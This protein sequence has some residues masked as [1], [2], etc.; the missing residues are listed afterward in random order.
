MRTKTI[1]LLLLALTTP[2]RGEDSQV[3]TAITKGQWRTVERLLANQNDTVS[4][5]RRGEARRILGYLDAAHAD[6]EIAFRQAETSEL[7]I[8]AGRTSAET[9]MAMNKYAE[10]KE[11]LQA[12]PNGCTAIECVKL[13]FLKGRL[14]AALNNPNSA[15]SAFQKAQNHAQSAGLTTLS[16]QA[17]LAAMDIK[18]ASE[19]ELAILI[20]QLDQVKPIY[21]Q[22]ALRL[23]LAERTHLA[24]QQTL[25]QTLLNQIAPYIAPGRQR[26][27]FFALQA[28]LLEDTKQ[29]PQALRT[30]GNGMQAAS[31]ISAGDLLMHGEWQR[32]RLYRALQDPQRALA[33]Y[34]RA[35]FYLQAIRCD[36]PIRYQSGKS[37]FRKTLGP[38]Y[39]QTVDLLLTQAETRSEVAA[40][41][42]LLEARNIIESLK[43]A[44]LQ[45]YLG[46]TCPLPTNFLTNLENISPRTGVLYPIILDDRLVLLLGIGNLQY[47]KVVAIDR[48]TFS[49]EVRNFAK[50]LRELYSAIPK[51]LANKMFNWLITPIKPRLDAAGIDTLVI[52]PDGPLRLFSLAALMNG[53][54]F[55][56]EDYAVVTAPGLSLMSAQSSSR[57]NIHALIAGMSV[58]GPVVDEFA[59]MQI[60]LN[61]P[62]AVRGFIADTAQ[63]R[64]RGLRGV[65]LTLKN[66]SQAP[67]NTIPQ[68]LDP[69]T[70]KRMV[71]ELSLPGVATEVTK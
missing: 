64:N 58:P 13:E 20:E 26:A 35:L 66:K 29:Y 9:L 60:R 15:L 34:R 56:I 47:Q 59:N 53:D 63:M 46:E 30:I 27:Q 67:Q 3:T 52:V 69:E 45:D 2:A 5:L 12:I 41:P 50:Q 51:E 4:L 18:P 49:S 6:H 24:G 40:Q 16:I 7:K 65:K 1:L 14:Q 11:R 39:L 55:L 28:K 32:G 31:D 48:Q 62:E 57:Q 23:G 25:T 44:E 70:R 61:G 68:P 36:I 17:Q 19:T 43:A 37:S 10:A 33:A 42:Y 71:Q 38:L 21:T 22:T 54:K 8:W